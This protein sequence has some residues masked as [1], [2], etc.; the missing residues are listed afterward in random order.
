MKNLRLVM[1]PRPEDPGNPTARA[2][3]RPLKIRVVFDDDSSARGAEVL[4]KHVTADLECDT[5]SFDF[6]DLDS[7]G[8]GLAAARNA[9]AHERQNHC[10]IRRHS[11]EQ[12]LSG[13]RGLT[14]G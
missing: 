11:R 1:H 9:S 5:R 10:A 14:G 3:E 13:N 4:I 6:D 2:T 7:S 8:T 12:R